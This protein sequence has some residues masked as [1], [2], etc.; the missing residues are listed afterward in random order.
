M[1]SCIFILIALSMGAALADT[2]SDLTQEFTTTISNG[3]EGVGSYY[4]AC[5]DLTN[6]TFATT[7]VNTQ[8]VTLPSKVVLN[9]VAFTTPSSTGGQSDL[10]SAKL[11]VYK[12]TGA[13]TTGDFITISSNAVTWTT[14]STLTFDFSGDITLSTADKYQF[15]FVSSTATAADVDTFAEYKTQ[16]GVFRIKLG[17]NTSTLPTGFGIYKNNAL[18]QTDGKY[19]PLVTVKTSPIPEPSTATLS[20]LALVG[21]VTRRRRQA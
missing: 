8:S 20:L 11:A 13:S 14:S 5:F 6:A 21:L 16:A 15:L 7:K 4:G 1:K 18:S 17:G 19:L 12:Y 2:A 10:S 3:G 9:S